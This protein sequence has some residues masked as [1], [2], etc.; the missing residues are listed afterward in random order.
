MARVGGCVCECS[1]GTSAALV[2]RRGCHSL[3]PSLPPKARY[4]C[5][6]LSNMSRKLLVHRGAYL[7][8]SALVSSLSSS[9]LSWSTSSPAENSSSRQD[10]LQV[11]H[12]GGI[13]PTGHLCLLPPA[14]SGIYTTSPRSHTSS[15]SL[16]CVVCLRVSVTRRKASR[17]H[18][19]LRSTSVTLPP[20]AQPYTRRGNQQRKSHIDVC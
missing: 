17:I 11:P 9:L 10:R 20:V 15:I 1:H 3:I 8:F 5:L 2:G 13:F 6:I 18:H 4:A 14:T 19:I 16:V 7:S 12:S